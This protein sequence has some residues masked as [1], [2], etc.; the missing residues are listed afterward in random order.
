MSFRDAEFRPASDEAGASTGCKPS[1]PA[2]AAAAVFGSGAAWQSAAASGLR[3]SVEKYR[4]SAGPARLTR[5]Q[6]LVGSGGTD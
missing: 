4:A 5:L 1:T 6:L 2:A 3:A